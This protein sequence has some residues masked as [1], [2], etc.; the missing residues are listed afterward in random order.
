MAMFPVAIVPLYWRDDLHFSMTDIFVIHAVFGL[1]AALFEF[2]GG[3]IAD[4]LGYRRSMLIATACSAGAWIVLGAAESMGVV[5]A[6]EFFLAISLSLTSGTDAALFYESLLEL[7]REGEFGRWFGRQRSLGAV[8]EGTAALAAGFLYVIWPPLPFFLQSSLWFFN[9]GVA[10]LLGLT[11]QAT[12]KVTTSTRVRAIFHYAVV[13]NPQLRSS[14]LVVL[15]LGLSTFIPVWIL[16]IYAENAGVS[17]LWIGPIWAAANYM[18]AL[19]H[20][21][22]DR[23]G[24]ALGIRKAL[25]GCV[26]LIA[27]GYAGLSM[28]H[29]LLG[30]LY[31]YAVCLARGL[32][33]PMLTHFQQRLIPSADRASLLS[34]NSLDPIW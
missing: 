9:M 4:R 26:V 16:A 34:I 11:T 21:S 32:N 27:L 23:V 28:S 20:W 30:F 1:F 15:A 24:A 17:V 22:S 14:I 3:Y 12:T 29:A 5:L 31:Y 18:V 7:G 19:G 10:F 2:P 6:G 8:A 13:G 33:G 25:A